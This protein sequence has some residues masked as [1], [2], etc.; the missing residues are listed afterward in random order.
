MGV[1]LKK[2]CSDGRK[3]YDLVRKFTNQP[4]AEKSSEGQN[5]ILYRVIEYETF[6]LFKGPTL[7]T[8]NPYKV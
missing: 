1:L 6:I 3:N 5:I 2:M 8:L 4:A 7:W